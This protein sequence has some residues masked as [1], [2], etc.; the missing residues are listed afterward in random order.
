[1]TEGALLALA[2][3]ALGL[4][5]AAFATGALV[6]G[7]ARLI[8]HAGRAGL[9]LRAL[10]FAVSASLGTTLLFAL[11][12]ALEASRWDV[13]EVLKESGP[14]A[15]ASKR[16]TAMRSALVASEIALAVVLVAGA[17]V[18]ARSLARLAS[19]DRGFDTRGVVIFGLSLPAERYP[20]PER[21]ASFF[22]AALSKV[23]A[24]PGVQAAGATRNLPTIGGSTDLLQIEG[25]PPLPRSGLTIRPSGVTPDYARAIGM[26]VRAGRFVEE[27]DVL[28]STPVIVVNKAMADRFFPGES[29]VG[30]RIRVD[31]DESPGA[32]EVW[33]AIVGVVEDMRS[34]SL[35]SS[36]MFETF[37]P[38]AQHP[39]SGAQFAVRVSIPVSSAYPQLQRAFRDVDVFVP[40]HQIQIGK[41]LNGT[42]EAFVTREIEPLRFA[43]GLAA[44]LGLIGL[45]LAAIGVFGVVSYAVEQRRHEFAVRLAL[46]ATPRDVLGLVLRQTAPLV[47][48]GVAVGLGA[49]LALVRLLS[50]LVFGVSP[51]DPASLVGAALVLLATALL[52]SYLPARRATRT[53]PMLA[54]RAD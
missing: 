8:P 16:A 15:T 39:S 6:T 11:A 48:V 41:D 24:L 28:G 4:V 2:G 3:G 12:P 42:L 43:A 40:I 36:P 34:E 27:S 53:S 44:V 7:F 49:A 22:A 10:G 25:R 17:G 47:T 45:L 54:L 29:P 46:G 18:L 52:A 35:R 32:E 21:R 23:K 51:L 26:R 50:A 9:D 5:L 14:R 13:H 30:R 33:Y 19:V 1:M 38:L 20:T 37:V 31:W